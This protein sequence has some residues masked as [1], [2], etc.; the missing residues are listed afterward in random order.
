MRTRVKRLLLAL[1]TLGVTALFAL[2]YQQLELSRRML[3]IVSWIQIAG[4]PGI[5]AYGVLYMVCTVFLL[6]GS[7]LTLGAGFA[8]GPLLGVA[9]V[10]PASILAASAAF[11]LGRTLL[12]SKVEKR[13]GS[14]RRIVAIDR[15]IGENGLTLVLLLRLSP[16][17]PFNFLNYALSLTRVSFRDFLLG[18]AVGM[19]PA[20]ILFVYF[21]SLVTRGSELLSPRSPNSSAASLFL[22]WG[23]LLATVV[24]VLLVSRIARRA[25]KTAFAEQTP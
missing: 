1:M 6:P 9:I 22:Y 5:V 24:M 7:L 10:S 2:A 3:A 16:L 12:R 18:S 23:G 20:T 17:F 19:L 21:G 11:V 25:L 15:A 14:D 8:W 4:L 13:I